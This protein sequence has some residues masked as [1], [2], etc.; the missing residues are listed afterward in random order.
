MASFYPQIR[1]PN[2]KKCLEMAI[3]GTSFVFQAHALAQPSPNR[4]GMWANT[5]V[6]TYINWMFLSWSSSFRGGLN[7]RNIC[8]NYH[9]STLWP[10]LF[11][12]RSDFAGAHIQTFPDF[13]SWLYYYYISISFLRCFHQFFTSEVWNL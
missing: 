6:C 2:C 7:I 5:S 3:L 1:N 9:L 4:A 13:E 8:K 10:M 11:I 12:R